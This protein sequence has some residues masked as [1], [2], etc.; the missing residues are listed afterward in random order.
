[1]NRF[2]IRGA[3]AFSTFVLGV[4]CVAIST[5]KLRSCVIDFSNDQ[6][7]APLTKTVSHTCEP[8]YDDNVVKELVPERKDKE[9]LKPD[10]QTLLRAFREVP[11]YAMPECV[12]EAY[13]LAFLPSFHP[14]VFV[15][16]WRSGNDFFLVAKRLDRKRAGA[17]GSVKESSAR[18]LTNSEWRDLTEQF[19]RAQYWD[20]AETTN[21]PLMNDGAAW[22][23]EGWNVRNY[24]RV[25]RRIPNDELAQISKRLIQLSGL[26]TAHDL[27]LP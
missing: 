13:S 23:L 25:F 21:E 27:Y 3:V 2:L 12:D 11:L 16:V 8:V 14:A 17:F 10:T 15:R 26:D 22:L 19:T 18:S 20:L 5:S 4:A 6:Q 24:H 7:P 1:M 9:Y